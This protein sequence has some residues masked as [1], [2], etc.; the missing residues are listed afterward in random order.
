MV[1]HVGEAQQ[2]HDVAPQWAAER[3]EALEAARSW[4]ERWRAIQ[5]ATIDG[6]EVVAL[7]FWRGMSDECLTLAWGV[8]AK[9]EEGGRGWRWR[10][11]V[12]LGDDE[13]RDARPVPACILE[14]LARHDP[15]ELLARLRHQLEV[16]EARRVLSLPE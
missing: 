4:L 8:L 3:P 10:H 2:A 5:P 7:A 12:I 11:Q 6:R 9:P 16:W 13:S 15:A 1:I 14:D